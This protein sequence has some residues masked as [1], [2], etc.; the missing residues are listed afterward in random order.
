M[1][2]I[3]KRVLL[4][5]LAAAPFV[6]KRLPLVVTKGPYIGD[7][8]VPLMVRSAHPELLWPGVEDWFGKHYG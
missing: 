7:P 1:A 8:V 3:S 2:D 5:L 6:P 4:G